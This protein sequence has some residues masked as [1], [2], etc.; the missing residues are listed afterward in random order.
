ML[1][2]HTIVAFIHGLGGGLAGDW[3]IGP[4]GTIRRKQ[5]VGNACGT[6]GLLH[7]TLNASV[8]KDIP[9]GETWSLNN[10][11]KYVIN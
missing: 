2:R 6:V 7:C 4:G 1:F 11:C 10:S 9:L 3:G 8:S 5:T